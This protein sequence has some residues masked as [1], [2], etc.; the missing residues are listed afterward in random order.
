M[1]LLLYTGK[2]KS[3]RDDEVLQYL[4]R[5]EER[6]RQENRARF[7]ALLGLIGRMVVVMEVQGQR[8]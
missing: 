4:E 3:P 6:Q 7:D 2:R 1:L 5:S 8:Q